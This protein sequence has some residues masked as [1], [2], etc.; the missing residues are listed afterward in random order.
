MS[1]SKKMDMYREGGD[2]NG[3][4]IQG[5]IG[6]PGTLHRSLRVPKGHKIPASKLNSALHSK[7]AL[8]RKRANLAKTLKSFHHQD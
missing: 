2:S 8:T 5:A 7:N 3:K 1:R 4:W 6:K